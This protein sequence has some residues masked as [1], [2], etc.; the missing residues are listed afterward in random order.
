MEQ[1]HL[2]DLEEDN[3]DDQRRFGKLSKSR[4]RMKQKSHK[5]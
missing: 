4:T 5:E 3:K 2:V 1:I